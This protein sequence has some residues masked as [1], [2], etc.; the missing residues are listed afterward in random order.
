L[1]MID[2]HCHILPGID[3]GPQS[4]DAA[5]SMCR[6]AAKDGI[7]TVVA[8]PHC[9][10]GRYRND[11]ASILPV[12]DLLRERIREEGIDLNL[13]VAG[14]IHIQPN[15]VS[16][17][18]DNECLRLGGRFVLVEVP[19]EVVP[20]LIGDFLF[21]LRVEGFSPI[22]THPERNRMIQRRP[23]ILEDWIRCGG[24]TQVT[25]MSFTGDFGTEARD[26]SFDLLNRG[27]VHCVA[28]DAHSPAGRKPILSRALKLLKEYVGEE[29][30]IRLVDGN[31]CRIL[32]G[33]DPLTVLPLAQKGSKSNE[34]GFFRKYFR[35]AE[36]CGF[37]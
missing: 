26:A 31:P 29:G 11:A 7:R 12:F 35:L 10:D 13:D 28:T 30:A 27:W 4:V 2:L 18:N 25:A 8:T 33:E 5:L 15:L 6:I 17:L 1:K 22:L 14:D 21:H 23:V 34:R 20:R 37:H 9:C 36:I 32:A 16:F 3:D 24:F 19:S